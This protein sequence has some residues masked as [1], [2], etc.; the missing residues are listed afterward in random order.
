MSECVSLSRFPTLTW[1]KR[2]LFFL[3]H[4]FSYIPPSLP[5]SSPGPADAESPWRSHW[6]PRRRV[7]RAGGLCSRSSLY[8]WYWEYWPQLF[9]SV[10]TLRELLYPSVSPLGQWS[11]TLV[12]RAHCSTC[13]R[14]FPA[15]T[16]L[17]H[18]VNGWVIIRV[19]HGLSMAHSFEL[20][21]LEQE[22]SLWTTALGDSCSLH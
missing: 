12:L 1:S 20:G 6:N 15:P 18:L 17:I 5:Q 9:S 7:Q 10:S 4:N 11:L 14:C 16:N 8:W 2:F 19:L 22:W 13:F 3:S 21:M